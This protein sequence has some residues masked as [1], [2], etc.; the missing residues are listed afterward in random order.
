MDWIKL[1]AAT[2][3]FVMLVVAVV[4]M[5]WLINKI[6]TWCPEVNLILGLLGSV[7]CIYKFYKILK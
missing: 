1:L 3:A 4:I 7:Y 6:A 2:L 5:N